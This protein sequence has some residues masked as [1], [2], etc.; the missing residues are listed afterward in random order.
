MPEQLLS[1]KFNASIWYGIESALRFAADQHD[2]L[3]DD[4]LV[5]NQLLAEL[6]EA[7]T[8]AEAASPKLPGEPARL[9]SRQH[10]AA[11]PQLPRF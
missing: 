11:A 4:Q 8:A 5:V 1:L 6:S 2:R 7:I 9:P 3:G 10:G